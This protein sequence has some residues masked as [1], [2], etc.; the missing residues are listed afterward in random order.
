MGK[1]GDPVVRFELPPE[2]S[3]PPKPPAPSIQKK[4]APDLNFRITAWA[5]P[6]P[7]LKQ[8]EPPVHMSDNPGMSD[9]LGNL[10]SRAPTVRFTLRLQPELLAAIDQRAAETGQ[11]DSQVVRTI[12]AEALT[13]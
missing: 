3:N 10:K 5:D 13:G 4:P 9:N 12:L 1:D 6:V 8:S 7:T 2:W 11:S